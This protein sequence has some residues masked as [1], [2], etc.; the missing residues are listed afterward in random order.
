V[1][2]DTKHY[3]TSKNQE[4]P[5]DEKHEAR[6]CCTKRGEGFTLQQVMEMMQ[7]LQEEVVVSRAN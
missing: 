7:A 2:Y 3:P 5:R 1:G 4:D 6:T